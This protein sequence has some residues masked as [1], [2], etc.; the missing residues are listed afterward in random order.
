[1][2]YGWCVDISVFQTGVP[3][4]TVYDDFDDQSSPSPFSP[5]SHLSTSKKDCILMPNFEKLF[6]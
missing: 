2:Q 5:T 3:Q 1:M 6:S 4:N